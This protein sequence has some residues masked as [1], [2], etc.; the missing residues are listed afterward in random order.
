[1]REAVKLYKTPLFSNGAL[2]RILEN[3][4]HARTTGD[5]LFKSLPKDFS[6]TGFTFVEHPEQADFFVVPQ[7]IK[8]LTPSVRAYLSKVC[9]EATQYK[10]HTILFLTGDYCDRVHIDF[11]NTVVFKASDYRHAL[12]SNEIIFAPFVEDLGEQ[13]GIV[14]RKK[15][16]KPIVSFCGYAGFPS[17]KS[18]LAYVVRNMLIDV[19]AFISRNPL[20]RVYKKGVYFRRKAM[21]TL[22]A[23]SRITTAF[24]IRNSF[25]G[26]ANTITSDP[27]ALRNEYIHNMIDSDFVLTP[28]G[29]ANYSSRFYEAL[30]L[31]RIPVLLDTDMVLPL[32]HLIDYSSCVLRIPYTNIDTMGETIANFYDSLTEE[33]F[34]NM[35]KAG[36][37]IFLQYLRYDAYFNFALQLLRDKG[38]THLR[39]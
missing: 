30:S 11:P 10:K 26:N 27:I 31:G 34:Q 13:K 28:K 14:L 19:S 29:D 1:M 7:P 35:Q 38:L 37:D 2:V 32:E 25:S 23:H 4:P 20:R 12:H 15:Q 24:V 39:G 33:Q 22:Q 8:T 21:R 9:A 6:Y 3:G 16:T 36:R 17:P 18:R 5:V